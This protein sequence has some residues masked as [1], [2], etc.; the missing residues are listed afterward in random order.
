[1]AIGSS[2]AGFG[3]DAFVRAA[4]ASEAPEKQVNTP[5]KDIVAM[6]NP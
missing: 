1:M 3:K 6:Q 2:T 4:I 5:A